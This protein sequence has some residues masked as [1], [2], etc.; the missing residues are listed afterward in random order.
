VIVEGKE[1]LEEGPKDE[2]TKEEEAT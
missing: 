2:E 1:G